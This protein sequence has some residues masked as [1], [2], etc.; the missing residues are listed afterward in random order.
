MQ[1]MGSV[2]SHLHNWF[3]A[4]D[5]V[6]EGTFTIEDGSIDLSDF[7]KDGQFFRICGSTFNDGVFA[8]AAE[9]LTDETFTGTIWALN[10]PPALSRLV[11]EIEDYENR[12]E[13]KPSPYKSES[14]G[15]YR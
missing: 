15:G 9:T 1:M 8:Y 14:F 4:P 10:V 3:V 5:G 7:L 2:L 11:A 12:A 13:A 6:H